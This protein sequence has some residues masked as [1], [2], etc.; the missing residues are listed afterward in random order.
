MEFIKEFSFMPSWLWFSGFPFMTFDFFHVELCPF[1][2]LDSSNKPWMTHVWA[3]KKGVA[4]T[5]DYYYIV[6]FASG[7]KRAQSP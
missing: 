6:R 3:T 2:I 4:T 1:E 5:D 7:H